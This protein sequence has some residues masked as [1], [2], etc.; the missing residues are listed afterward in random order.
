MVLFFNHIF[1]KKFNEEPNPLEVEMFMY[2]ENVNTYVIAEEIRNRGKREA[3][4][5]GEE[6]Y[7]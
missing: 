7:D 1:K 4:K 2:Q 3:Q 6:G 5:L